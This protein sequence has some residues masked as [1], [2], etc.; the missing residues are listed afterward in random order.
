M[1]KHLNISI[2]YGYT[3]GEKR[4]RHER[5]CNSRFR[6]GHADISKEKERSIVPLEPTLL[7]R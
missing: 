5:G 4:N 1:E 3:Y 6:G 2:I 7:D